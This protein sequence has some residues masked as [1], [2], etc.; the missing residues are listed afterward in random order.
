MF[1]MLSHSVKRLYREGAKSLSVPLIAFTLVV[2]INLL[3]GI[4]AWLEEEYEDMMDNFP[5]VAVLSN[6]EGS[7]VNDLHIDMRYISLFTDPDTFASLARHTDNL[8]LKRT[9]GAVKI[10][11]SPVFTELIG[12]TSVKADDIL[13]PELGVDIMF[14]EGYDD[15]FLEA[16]GMYGLISEDLHALV[17]NGVLSITIERQ[18]PDTIIEKMVIPSGARLETH[19]VGDERFYYLR[20]QPHQ[21]WT[22]LEPWDPV[23][24]TTVIKGEVVT[25]E[26]DLTVIGTISGTR[27]G[28]LYSPFWTVSALAAEVY[29][30]PPF[31]ERLSI[32]IYENRDL[33][34]FKGSAFMSFPRVR[35]LHDTR[36]F[37]MTIYDSVFYETVEPLRQNIIVVDV[38][39]P[40]IYL[41]SI[42]V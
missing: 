15:S 36:P 27:N 24:E 31:S 41:L 10:N 6:L 16:D 21:G 39:T 23:Y 37:A 9:F 8:I 11:G 38:A 2:L 35:P 7:E 1:Y 26:T 29:D 12:I 13:D 17:E 40:F 34:A 42:A 22:V 32:T 30:E 25:V 4:K 3:G 33:S 14:F 28:L 18:L 20:T 19:I 5:V